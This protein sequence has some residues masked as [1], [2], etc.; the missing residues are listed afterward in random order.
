[1]LRLH[2]GRTLTAVPISLPEDVV[3]GVEEIAATDGVTRDAEPEKELLQREQKG[4][5][6]GWLWVASSLV[7]L[8]RDHRGPPS[9]RSPHARLIDSG[10]SGQSTSWW[11]FPL[12]CPFR[13]PS[14]APVPLRV[15]A[16]TGGATA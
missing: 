16:C 5:A 10:D 14:R 1:M 13:F 8:G 6:P 4:D 11:P 12:R 15:P 9:C 2:E 3:I 7:I